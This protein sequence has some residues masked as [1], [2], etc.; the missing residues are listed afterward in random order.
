MKQTLFLI[1]CIFIIKVCFADGPVEYTVMAESG[2]NLYE[3]NNKESAVLK[4]LKYGEI[5]F[6]MAIHRPIETYKADTIDGVSGYWIDASYDKVNGFVFSPYVYLGKLINNKI[7]DKTIRFT[8]EGLCFGEVDYHPAL[9][10][11]GFYKKDSTFYLKKIKLTMH[12]SKVEGLQ[13]FEGLDCVKSLEN[14]LLKT[15]QKE[16]SLFLIGVTKDLSEGEIKCLLYNEIKSYHSEK[17][18]L[19]L[20]EEQKFFYKN[21]SYNIKAIE[22]PETHKYQ[23]VYSINNSDT[24]NISKELDLQGTVEQHQEYT[25][26]RLYWIGDLNKD[27][28]LDFIIYHHTMASGGGVTWK[29]TLFLSK[30]DDRV[31]ISKA[32]DAIVA[33]CH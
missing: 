10:W 26:P 31:P 9:K 8:K 20:N 14:I 22:T 2:I 12:L 19:A 25:T 4:R 32:D 7:N 16:K 1:I 3:S 30:L 23:L 24:I 13:L 11:Y 17:G 6:S 33:S 28:I 15:D 18:F 27:D 29:H 21:K 5:I